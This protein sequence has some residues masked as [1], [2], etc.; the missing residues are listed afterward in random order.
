VD[1]YLGREAK[2]ILKIPQMVIVD[3]TGT[4]RA[5][6][7]PQGD[8]TLENESSL[9]ALLQRLLHENRSPPTDFSQ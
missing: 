3:R 8:P 1:Q 7:G 5:A 9:R 2:Q 6:S 4:I